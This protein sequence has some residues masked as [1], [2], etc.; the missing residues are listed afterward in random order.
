MIVK[1][2]RRPSEFEISLT[3]QNSLLR[4]TNG[5]RMPK[6]C[7]VFHA[8]KNRPEWEQRAQLF[9]TRMIPSTIEQPRKVLA[10][11]PPGSSGGILFTTSEQPPCPSHNEMHRR[12]YDMK[13]ALLRYSTDS[14]FISSNSI[15]AY[16]ALYLQALSVSVSFMN[17]SYLN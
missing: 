9:P 7:G 8:T 4:C 17:S 11:P 14:L 6:E 10:P 12:K 13:V 16:P 3:N 2:S 5:T 15:N 1:I